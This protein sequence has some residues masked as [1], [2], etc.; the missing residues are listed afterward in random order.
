MSSKFIFAERKSEKFGAKSRYNDWK[1]V[2]E[3]D[4][5]RYFGLTMLM[6]IVRKPFIEDYWSTNSLLDTPY[7]RKVLPRNR[8][9]MIHRMIK[10]SDDSK[11]YP[12]ESPFYDPLH[13]VRHVINHLLSR[14]H[15]AYSPECELAIDEG[16][17][18]WKG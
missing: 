8:Y 9:Q 2:T 12:R 5:T 15:S 14:F 17:V 16:A 13:K 6:G 18:P 11:A 3:L 1:D 10:F 4:I 7:F